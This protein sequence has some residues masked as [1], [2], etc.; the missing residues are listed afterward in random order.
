MTTVGFI[1]LGTIGQPMAL[2]LARAVPELVVWNR[3]TTRSEP[4]RAAGARVAATSAE[5]FVLAQVVILML[6]DA[7]AAD[8]VLDGAHLDGRTVVHMGTISPADSLRLDATVRAGGGAYVEAPVSGSRVP[9]ERGEL[10]AMLAGETDVVENVRPLLAPMCR[11]THVCGPVP[12]ALTMKLA[13]NI[14]MLSTVVGLVEAFHFA[15]RNGLDLTTLRAIADSGQMA[16][17][18]SRVKSAK[19]LDRDFS[20]QAGAA[21]VLKNI[22]LMSDAARA[23]GASGP[24]TETMHRLLEETVAA[25]HGTEDFI[26]LLHVLEAPRT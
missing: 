1:G 21:D 22:R 11:E 24:L 26:A 2:N 25:G 8:Q 16:S 18:I 10:I 20:L 19:L 5:V 13:T 15:A 7:A 9:A 3:T 6:A 14:F 12:D 4:L 23:A 17:S